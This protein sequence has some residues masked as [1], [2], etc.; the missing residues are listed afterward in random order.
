MLLKILPSLLGLA[1]G[2]QVVHLEEA[3]EGQ[4]ALAVQV[5]ELCDLVSGV[6]I[7]LRIDKKCDDE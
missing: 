6:L 5:Q 7:E 3:L 4:V 1:R 2:L